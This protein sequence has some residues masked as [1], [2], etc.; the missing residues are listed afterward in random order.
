MRLAPKDLYCKWIVVFL[1]LAIFPSLAPAQNNGPGRWEES[2]RK[3]E[4]RD[5]AHPI[6]PGAILF[7][8]SSSI[9]MWTDVDHYFPGY[10]VLNRGF[11]GSEFSDLIH[12]ADRVIYPYAPSMIFVYEGDNDIA[13]GKP[14][15]EILQQA[16]QLRDMIRQKLNNTP[17]IFIS[18]KPS[19]ARWE[20][21]ATYEDLNNKLKKY[22]DG[23]PDTEFADVWTPAIGS[24]GKVLS[25]I[26][27]EDNLHMNAEGYKIWQRVLLPYLQRSSKRP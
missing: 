7:V 22:A 12:F 23:E 27:R 21:R 16:K 17:V 26:F 11:G 1:I 20:L 3:F 14:G 19:V 5:K 6:S 15:E 8:G 10:R 13:N 9:A 18:P 2:I 25:N 24:D 4:E